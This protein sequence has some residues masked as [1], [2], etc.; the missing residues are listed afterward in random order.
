M[1]ATQGIEE[2]MSLLDQSQGATFLILQA[3]CSRSGREEEEEGMREVI[4]INKKD[5][6]E[7]EIDKPTQT[8]QQRHRREG[9]REGG[10]GRE[11]ERLQGLQRLRGGVGGR[12]SIVH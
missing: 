1:L 12:V 11:R 7:K 4:E 10:R 8:D 3:K 6:R 9:G 5:D 2:D